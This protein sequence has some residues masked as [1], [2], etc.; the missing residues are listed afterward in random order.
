MLAGVRAFPPRLAARAL[1]AD[2]EAAA[3][4]GTAGRQLRPEEVDK[5]RGELAAYQEFAELTS[6]IADMS[7]AICEARP[8]PGRPLSWRGKIGQRTQC[9]SQPG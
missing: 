9:R 2:S 8:V 1:G 5:V 4:R 7:E 6:Q 3:G